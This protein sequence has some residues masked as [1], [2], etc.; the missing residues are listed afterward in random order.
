MALD[1]C[2]AEE[3]IEYVDID[4]DGVYGTSGK[5]YCSIDCASESGDEPDY[6]DDDDEDN[7]CDYEDQ[8]DDEDEDDEELDT[9]DD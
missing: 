5:P 4:E 3:C 6:A 1:M 9:D 2:S 7:E 8:Y